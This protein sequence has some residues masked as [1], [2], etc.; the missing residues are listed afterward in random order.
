[1]SGVDEFDDLDDYLD[2]FEEEILSQEPGA[3]IIPETINEIDD[4]SKIT[5]SIGMNENLSNEISEFIKQLDP[6]GDGNELNDI[7]NSKEGMN[8][9]MG[10]QD[11]INETINRL[12]SSSKQ[13]EDESSEKFTKDEEL[14]TTLLNSLDIGGDIG[15]M[16]GMDE[17]KGLLNGNNNGGINDENNIDEMSNVLMNMLNKL[18]SKEMMYETISNAVNNYE[19]Y[20]KKDNKEVKG[21]DMN[22]F[23][24]QLKHLKNVKETF[25]KE[26]Y[27]EN[28]SSIRE[29][30]DIEMENFN[31]LLPPPEG[32]IEDNLSGLGL[33]NF[34]WNEQDIPN[35]LEGC[36]QQ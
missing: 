8:G 27:N 36:V 19:E 20:F 24:S 18:T 3:T 21:D 30:I 26:D 14:L 11:T 10:F 13:V 6:N 35:E 1:M 16:E 4:I 9:N 22:R 23:K 5:Q 34:K 33:E 2:D 15:S 17:L 12:K 25:D 28:D 7:L 32:V 29:F 31:K